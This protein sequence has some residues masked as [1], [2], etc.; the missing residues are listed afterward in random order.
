M[1]PSR[2]GVQVLDRAFAI[3]EALGTARDGL[4]LA[5]LSA[6]LD[7]PKPTI[8]RLLRALIAHKYARHD[9]QSGRYEIGLRA[10]ELGRAVL[11]GLDLRSCAK[12]H[13]EDLAVRAGESAN[14]AV[15]DRG[16]VVYIDGVDAASALRIPSGPGRRAPAHATALGKALLAALDARALAGYLVNSLE[17]LTECTVQD[18][19][20][21]RAEL[22]ETASRGYAVEREEFEP[23]VACVASA[24]RDANGTVVAALG[25]SGPA[26]RMPAQRVRHVLGPL[27]M[28][29]AL[30][31]SRDMGW[32]PPPLTAI[33]VEEV[34]ERAFAVGAASL[35]TTLATAREDDML[36]DTRSA[37]T[38]ALVGA[39]MTL[40]AP[41]VLAQEMTLRYAH[42]NTPTYP[43]HIAGEA[44]AEDIAAAT[45]GDIE[46]ELFPQGQLGHERDV[47]E[48]LQLGTIDFAAS[49][50]GVV[51]N[52]V[53]VIQ[54]YNLP[55][56]FA[57]PDHFVE[58]TRGE[59]GERIM[60][61]AAEEGERAGVRVLGV[62]G[63]MFRMPMNSARA[64]ETV[65]DFGGLKFRTMEVPVHR[66]TYAALGATPVPLPFGEVFT[67]LQTGVVDG[68]EN[69]LAALFANRFHEV[70][71][72]VSTLPVVSNGG[73]LLMSEVTWNRLGA[74]QQD[75]VMQAAARW[76]E[77]MNSEG[78]RQEDEA[79]NAL[80]QAGIAITSVNDVS[81]FVEAT[82]SVHDEVTAD[83]PADRK[84]LAEEILQSQ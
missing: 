69:G 60:A 21:L 25:I 57:G 81:P 40:S 18:E 70:Q 39:A 65:D 46:V 20:T 35:G 56:I 63:P 71:A 74:E 45:N 1:V 28:I 54:V 43:Y 37:M 4:T 22:A 44:L 24:V 12:R 16:D 32:V 58:V 80:K 53:P 76:V 6:R 41:H 67:A 78:R 52:E 62:G 68:N 3:L 51:G 26:I 79:L 82:R 61:I 29:A 48:G 66:D 31:V 36:K 11:D 7:L 55:F 9:R 14:L 64:I 2:S 42:S 49:S 5:D 75:A 83:W 19:A 30:G 50:L 15:L 73:V 27:V 23:G 8:H 47:L 84:A 34:Q 77:V 13:L 72:H 17:R 38:G 33:Q 10:L 59:I